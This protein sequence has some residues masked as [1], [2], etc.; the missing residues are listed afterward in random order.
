M[1]AELEQEFLREVEASALRPRLKAAEAA[2]PFITV[3]IIRKMATQAPAIY[4]AARELRV[5]GHRTTVTMDVLCLARNARGHVE[6]QH[7]DGKTIGLY[8]I[9]D[10]LL[11]LTGPGSTHGFKATGG[12]MDRDPAWGEAGL[13]AAVIAIE[14]SE[15]VPAEIDVDSLAPFLLFHAEHSLVAGEAE[16]AAVDEVTLPQ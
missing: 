15:T 3:E 2:P 6:A 10:A 1:L 8:E 7:G 14:V 5:D 16:P 4:V 9:T 11:A 12:R 13:A